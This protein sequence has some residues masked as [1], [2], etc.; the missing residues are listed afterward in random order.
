MK[1]LFRVREEQE[2]IEEVEEDTKP[3]G[4]I[5][6]HTLNTYQGWDAR[7]VMLPNESIDMIITSPPYNA[8]IK[9]ESW[10]DNLSR[11]EYAEFVE[12][13]LT[14]AYRLLKPGGRMAIVIAN[15]GRK[16]YYSNTNLY[17]EKAEQIGFEKRGEIIWVK[18]SVANGIAWGSWCSPSNPSLRDLHEYILV[19]HKE[20]P[21]LLHAANKVTDLTKDEFMLYT[22]SVWQISPITK[23]QASG[24]P[25]A[26]PPEIPRRL[27]KLYTYKDDIIFDPFVGAGTTCEVADEL[28]RK[29]IGSDLNLKYIFKKK[30]VQNNRKNR[31][32][33]NQIRTDRNV[34]TIGI[35]PAKIKKTRI[36]Y[37]KAVEKAKEKDGE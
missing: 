20:S 27:I 9:Y 11:E 2:N 16:P 3:I 17:T 6:D 28:G 7:N 21:K 33:N 15:V 12:S 23:K 25:A 1:K 36:A 14:E 22:N 37:E 10:D 13:F 5:P 26:F 35:T 8:D 4:I 30:R 29:W 31:E 19:F 34:E 32:I 18:G 24:H